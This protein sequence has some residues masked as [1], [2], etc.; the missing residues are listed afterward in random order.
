M[1]QKDKSRASKT[2]GRGTLTARQL[3]SILRM[4]QALARLEMRMEVVQKDVDEAI[5]LIS[6][7]K[8]SVME[9]ETSERPVD[10]DYVSRIWGILRDKAVATHRPFREY[11][12]LI[13]T[14]CSF[15]SF[16]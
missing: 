3:L 2:G 6:V 8:A 14:F 12:L 7:S 11:S 1:R 4:S 10:S 16:M 5:R 13:R 15:R 9:S